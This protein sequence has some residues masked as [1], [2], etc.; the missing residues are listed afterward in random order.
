[1]RH[2]VGRHSDTQATPPSESTLLI[3]MS[4]AGEPRHGYAILKDVEHLSEGR[5][6]LSTGTLYGAL[7]RLLIDRWIEEVEDEDSARDRRTYRLAA[8]GHRV[9]VSEINKMKRYARLATSRIAAEV[10]AQ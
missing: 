7:K 6:V 10:P 8:A 3:L 2:V 9:L 4:L 1:M 5:V